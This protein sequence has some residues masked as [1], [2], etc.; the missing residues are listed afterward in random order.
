MA[1]FSPYRVSGDFCRE[2]LIS[3]HPQAQ[4]L[5]HPSLSLSFFDRGDAPEDSE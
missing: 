1:N 2:T 3:S 4:Q 5:Q